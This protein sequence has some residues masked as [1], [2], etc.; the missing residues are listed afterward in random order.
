M[1][2]KVRKTQAKANPAPSKWK[3]ARMAV[4]SSTGR[5]L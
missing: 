5:H 1:S 3:S 4:S 2:C